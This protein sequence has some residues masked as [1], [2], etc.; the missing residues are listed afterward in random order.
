MKLVS[1]RVKMAFCRGGGVDVYPGQVLHDMPE[2]EARVK[3]AVGWVEILPPPPP[4]PAT[5]PEAEKGGR[6]NGKGK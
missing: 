3:E 4:A 1:V 5:E 2:S 6:G